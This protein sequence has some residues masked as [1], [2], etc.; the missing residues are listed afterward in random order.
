MRVQFAC[1]LLLLLCATGFSQPADIYPRY[2]HFI[3]QHVN[4]QMSVNRCDAVIRSKG[5]T[6]TNSNECKEINTFIRANLNTIKSI[7][8]HGGEPHGTMTKS[9]QPFDIVVCKLKNQNRHPHCEYRGQSRTRRI[10]IT[11]DGGYPVHLDGD[12]GIMRVQFACWL[13]LLLCATGF[14]Q[15]AHIYP[16]YQHFINQHVNRQMSVNSCDD[17]IRSK[18]ITKTNSNEC[19]ET[20]TFIRANL[21]TIKSICE[22]GGEPHGTMTKSLQPFDIVVCSLRN[23]NRH[24]HCEYRGERSVYWFRAG[25]D[26]SLTSIIYTP[27]N[28][29][30]ECEKSPETPSPPQ[31][32]VYSFSKNI[33]HVAAFNL[34]TKDVLRRNGDPGSL[35][36]FSISFH[37]QLNPVSK[38]LLLVGA[39]RS[40]HQNQANATGVVYQCELTTTSERCQ[41]IEFDNDEFLDSKGIHD[42]WMGVRVTSQGP[43][44][45]I[46]TCA[47]RYQQWSPSPNL[48]IPHL[49]TGQCYILDDDLHVGKAKR[50]WR[51]VVCD[52]EHLNR[53]QKTHEWFAYCQQGHGASFAKDNRSVL[54]GAPGAYLWKGIVRMELLDN[55]VV[56]NEEPRETGDIDQLNPRLIPIQRNS[57]LGFSID[58]GMALTRK[59]EL[60]IVSGAPRGGYSGQVTFLKTDPL[61][62]RSLSVVLVLSGP[63]LASSFGYDVA[64]VDLNGD[65]WD[66]LAVGAPQFFVKDGEVGGAVYIYINN[67]GK[68]W[69]KIDPIHLLGHKDSMFGLAVENIGDVNQDGYGDI[70]VGAP[71]DGSGRV[72]LYYGSSDGINK[73]AAQV[74]SSGS[75]RI[76]LF[77]YSL[78]GNLDV[79]DNQ[80]PDLAVGSLSDSVFVFRARPV[81]NVS[82]KLKL[83]PNEIDIT[84]ERCDKFTC[85][86]TARACF[87]YTAHPGSFNP[88]LMLNYTFEADAGRRK[89][90]LPPR[91]EFQG[92]SW[93]GLELPGQRREI[94]TDTKLRLLRDIKDRLH[95]IPISISVSLWS[96]SQTARQSGDLPDVTPVLNLYQRNNAVSE[97]ILINKGCGRDNICQSNLQLQYKFCSTQKQHDRQVFNSLHREN[98][99]AVLSPS[100]EDIALEITVNNQEGDDA[101]QSHSVITLPDTL[102]YSSTV[103]NEESETQVSCTANDKGTLIDCELG[104]PFQRDAEVTFYV[105]LS[106]ARIS[107]STTEVNVTLQLETTSVQTIQPIE[108]IVKVVFEIQLQVF[109]LATPSQVSFGEDARGESAIKSEDE[110]GTLVHYE[111]RITNLGRPLS[112]FANASLNIYW[113]KENSAGKW[114]LYLAQISSEGVQSVPCSPVQEI[115]SMK[116]LEGWRD[117]SRK[118]REAELEAFSTDGFTF[119]SK[120]RKYKTLTCSDGVKCV[121]IR[122]PLLGLDSTGVVVLRSRLWHSTFTEDYSS[123]NYLD[124][125]VD[126]TLSLSDS[127]ENIGL[128]PEKP[129]AKVKLTVFP[130]RKAEYLTRVAWWIILLTVLAGLLLLAALGFLLWKGGCIKCPVHNK[131]SHQID[132]NPNTEVSHPKA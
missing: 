97:I 13:L 104:N 101:H 53:R 86:F 87:T 88:K 43:G 40:K 11:C 105:M 21:K 30:V 62:E 47:H 71:Y 20:N 122:C 22:H 32:C 99:I 63:G 8:E 14:S 27:E 127:P 12:I 5:I 120:R 128:K 72:Y 48:Y 39:P 95:S 64:V 69:E 51:R 34:D 79:D 81:V 106:T 123:L 46:M 130:A 38:K 10:A 82:H 132:E 102:R 25:S 59:G 68:D 55:L 117:I 66:D 18:G 107:L 113:P 58:S 56:S 98:G 33:L 89:Q 42:Q 118:R 124:I 103:Y 61:A 93:G 94:C 126:A 19:K 52:A 24:P 36:G 78:S 50:T 109:G 54:F 80:Y 90:R 6:K 110:I 60:T 28:R 100:D 17:V 77:G 121:Q 45:S 70:A 26:E 35:F 23:Q 125:V 112:S 114:L 29:S 4:R 131:S 67:K 116:H 92:S 129:G 16:R 84:K 3:D 119:L 57:F 111:F 96:S 75:K 1:W 2:K 74:L 85:H 83:T 7:C 41:P 15:P 44:K 31:S 65:G 108:A 76:T 9:L 37:Q 91:M 73:K 49:V 115:N